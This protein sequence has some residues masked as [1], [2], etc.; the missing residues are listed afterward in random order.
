MRISDWSSDV[1]SSDLPEIVATD[2]SDAALTR[3]RE[4]RY[5]QFEIQRGLPVRRMMQWFERDGADWVA[6]PELVRQVQFR[7]QN[8][9]G[10][11]PPVGRFDIVL[12]RNVLLYLAAG[13]RRQIFDTFAR[14]EEHTSALH[15]LMRI[16]YAVLGV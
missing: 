1:C 16:S 10:D 8:L 3:A 12:F 15:A 2:V 4:G 7:R 14:S 9:V 6:R 13:M 11:P 5:S